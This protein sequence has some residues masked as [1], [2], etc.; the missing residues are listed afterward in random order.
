MD[1][2]YTYF[3][4]V[5]G[6]RDHARPDYVWSCMDALLLLHGPLLI[7]T[8]ACP[9]G[10]DLYA[11]QW[12][13]SRQQIYMGFPAQWDLYRQRGQLKRAGMARNAEMI[14]ITSPKQAVIF[15]G[16]RGTMNMLSICQQWKHDG[17][18]DVLWLPE[19]DFWK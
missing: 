3:V 4:L 5:S 13:K 18:L 12:A 7:I 10:A 17:L 16:G 14:A 9:T 19:G 8:G 11:E 15:Q 6:G 2:E 1:R